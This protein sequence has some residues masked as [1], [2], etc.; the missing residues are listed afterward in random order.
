M[1]VDR[2]AG[3]YSCATKGLAISSVPST[4][5]RRVTVGPRRTAKPRARVC[6]S[7]SRVRG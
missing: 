1:V 3:V 6:G 2:A 5:L 4:G 7:G